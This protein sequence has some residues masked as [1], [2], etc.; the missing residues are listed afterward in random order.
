MALINFEYIRVLDAKCLDSSES[1]LV[2]FF[3]QP[4]LNS[5]SW[6]G[7]VV[8]GPSLCKLFSF[9]F[10]FLFFYEKQRYYKIHQNHKKS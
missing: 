6:G 7:F 4:V 8:G 1:L 10:V 9:S 5:Y 3:F 2:G